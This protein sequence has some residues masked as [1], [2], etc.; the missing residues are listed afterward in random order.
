MLL[1]TIDSYGVTVLGL[2]TIGAGVSFLARYPA[3]LKLTAEV[4]QAS[5]YALN[6]D[7]SPSE[8]TNCIHSTSRLKDTNSYLT[9][10]FDKRFF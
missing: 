9:V 1:L 8:Y 2:A 4:G 10:L 7:M 5:V 6:I 3:K